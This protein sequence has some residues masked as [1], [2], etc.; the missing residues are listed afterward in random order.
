MN[1][2]NKATGSS[3]ADYN[4]QNMTGVDPSEIDLNKDKSEWSSFV[5]NIK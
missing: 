4:S 2:N 3:Q 1:E 5:I